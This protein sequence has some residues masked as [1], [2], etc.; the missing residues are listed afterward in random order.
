MS[1]TICLANHSTQNFRQ[2]LKCLATRIADMP[3]TI[4][5]YCSMILLLNIM[6]YNFVT[7]IIGFI[8]CIVKIMLPGVTRTLLKN[9][10]LSVTQIL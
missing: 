9:L 2:M 4:E 1:L 3:T 6:M 10:R 5:L 7:K 8:Y